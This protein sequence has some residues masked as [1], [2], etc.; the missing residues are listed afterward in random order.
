MRR[1]DVAV[2]DGHVETV[3]HGHRRH[4]H[5]RNEILFACIDA[6]RRV[7]DD[8][9]RSVR[10]S[11]HPTAGATPMDARVDGVTGPV[12]SVHTGWLGTVRWVDRT[13]SGRYHRAAAHVVGRCSASRKVE[14]HARFHG[15]VQD[16]MPAPPLA[17]GVG[18][19]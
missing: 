13:Q 3:F 17:R 15:T 6:S 10:T 7:V 5:G 1:A 16:A 2:V 14:F 12:A 4:W 19:G 8:R 18:R 11:F 9:S